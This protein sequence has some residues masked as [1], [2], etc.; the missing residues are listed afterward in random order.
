MYAMVVAM[1]LDNLRAYEKHLEASQPSQFADVYLV[2]SKEEFERSTALT[3]T[4]TAL[5]GSENPDFALRIFDG[6]DVTAD[7]LFDELNALPLFT[8]RRVVVVKQ[9]DKA[10]KALTKALE[11]YLSHPNRSVKLVMCAEAVAAN[12]TFY[13][14][15][16]KVG[17]V[18]SV[19][20]KKPWE[21]EEALCEWLLQE[22]GKTGKR[23]D[24]AAAK[25]LVKQTGLDQGML[26]NELEKLLCYTID[27]PTI[28]SQAVAA[29]C[30]QLD[31]DTIWLFNEAILRRQ[32][33]KAL[34]IGAQLLQD[35]GSVIGILVQ[36]RTQLHTDYQVCSILS[37]GGTT[38]DV[39]QEFRHFVGRIL[40]AHIDMARG[41]GMRRFKQGLLAVDE[42]ER[43]AKSSS[44]EPSLLLERLIIKLTA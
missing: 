16:E 32:A 2:L 24:P 30:T 21:K 33:A 34:S 41:Y 36:L 29:I 39:A 10:K 15:C 8:A 1:K 14:T 4:T 20:A 44:M 35:G 26:K 19:A 22:V 3:T 6:E 11:E 38:Q 43:A 12:T 40:T 42:A 25:Q 7:Q 5:V 28:T 18:L 37:N 13:K 27:Q 17:V 23:I 31:S 9:V